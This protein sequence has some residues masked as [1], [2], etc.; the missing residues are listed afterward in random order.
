VQQGLAKTLESK[1]SKTGLQLEWASRMGAFD[2]I[3]VDR[4]LLH[5][6]ASSDS[7]FSSFCSLSPNFQKYLIFF[8]RPAKQRKHIK[9]VK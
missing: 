4:L 6:I 2:R 3:A 8:P 5:M 9:K 7:S 1:T